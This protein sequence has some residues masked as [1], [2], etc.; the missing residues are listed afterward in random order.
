M[1]NPNID[2]GVFQPIC[3]RFM[4]LAHSQACF[5]S[6]YLFIF[7]RMKKYDMKRSIF[8]CIHCS[9]FFGIHRTTATKTPFNIHNVFSVALSVWCS[10]S[11]TAK[12]LH[13]RDSC[14]LIVCNFAS[15]L[16]GGKCLF[17]FNLE[18]FFV[19]FFLSCSILFVTLRIFE[20]DFCTE[21][22]IFN[23]TFST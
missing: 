18:F 12:F 20:C 4:C 22:R 5:R 17:L 13:R 1:Y 19:C 7:Y 3:I 8:I 6:L 10:H 16:A 14:A 23:A 15:K 11:R 9:A 21:L 2:D